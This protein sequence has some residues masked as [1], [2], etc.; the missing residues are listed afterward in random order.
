MTD[1]PL[2]PPNPQP[3]ERP[4]QF[5]LLNLFGLTTVVSVCAAAFYWNEVIGTMVSFVL[6]LSIAT[7]Y[8]TK[9][10]IRTAAPSLR[11]RSQFRLVGF[12]VVT[13]FVAA[14]GSLVAFCVVCTG[15]GVFVAA[16]QPQP[17]LPFIIL[18]C[19]LGLIPAVIVLYRGWPRR[20]TPK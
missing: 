11:A 9:A 12:G 10:V 13:S 3:V 16:A 14:L 20:P 6:F 15:A 7:F 17:M 4:W 19:L 18:A 1:E 2:Q 8:R 5:S